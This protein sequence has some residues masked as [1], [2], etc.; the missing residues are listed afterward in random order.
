MDKKIELTKQEEI[1]LIAGR[2]LDE[3]RKHMVTLPV[4]WNIIAAKKIHTQWSEYFTQ[5]GYET[6]L[7]E[8]DKFT[9]DF[10]QWVWINKY[11]DNNDAD[12]LL[13]LYKNLK[14]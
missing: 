3:W 10:L 8:K 11:T 5:K 13:H 1:N 6:A 2:I 9:I 12:E 14:G 4:D 7:E